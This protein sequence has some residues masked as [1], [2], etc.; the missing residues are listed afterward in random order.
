MRTGKSWAGDRTLESGLDTGS[1]I[2]GVR[3]FVGRG[4]RQRFRIRMA[5]PHK[6]GAYPHDPVVGHDLL[7]AGIPSVLDEAWKLPQSTGGV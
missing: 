6:Y 5:H 1:R 4:L 7:D 2:S 3:E